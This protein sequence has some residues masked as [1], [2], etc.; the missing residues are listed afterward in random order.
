MLTLQ[1]FP[2]FYCNNCKYKEHQ[3]FACGKLGSSDVSS[4]AEVYFVTVYLS[5]TCIVCFF[6]SGK[7]AFN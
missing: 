1:D 3:C 6:T 5:S 2:N 7:I 4:K